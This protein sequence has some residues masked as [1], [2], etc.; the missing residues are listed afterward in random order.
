MFTLKFRRGECDTVVCGAKYQINHHHQHRPDDE[1]SSVVG[2]TISVYAKLDDKE[3]VDF[4]I[5]GPDAGSNLDYDLAFI[6]NYAGKTIDR[7]GPFCPPAG[8]AR[9]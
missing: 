9:D 7:V 1:P 8:P 6:E 4:N 2:A 3:G 5:H